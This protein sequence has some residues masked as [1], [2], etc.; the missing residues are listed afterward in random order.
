MNTGFRHGLRASGIICC[1]LSFNTQAALV[2]LGGG[3][4]QQ[5]GEAAHAL[6]SPS[7]MSAVTGSRI[8]LTPLEVCNKAINEESLSSFDLAGSHNNR[9]VLLFAEGAQQQALEDFEQALAVVDNIGEI[10]VNRGLTLSALGRWADSIPSFD[11]GIELQAP[12]LARAHMNRAIAHEE[13]GN[14]GAAYY[15]YLKASELAPEW[16]EPK[17]Q[18]QR[19][20]VRSS[21]GG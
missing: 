2:V 14:A 15:D 9:G 1:L 8:G 12:D 11:R 10:H 5:C 3:Y 6:G 18:L 19:F 21:P 7:A 17:L 20:S 13:L 16:D 4:A